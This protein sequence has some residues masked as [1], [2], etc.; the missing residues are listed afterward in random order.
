M[1][2]QPK[3]DSIPV[4]CG[5]K[6]KYNSWKT[7]FMTCVDQVPATPEHKLLHLR[8]YLK[9]DALKVVENL[10]HSEVAYEATKKR[11]ERKYG[12]KG[13]QIAINIEEINQFKPI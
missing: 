5:D 1:W 2:K 8:S 11:L 10:G 3:R 12:R 9:R 13:T 4:F 7:A 6:R